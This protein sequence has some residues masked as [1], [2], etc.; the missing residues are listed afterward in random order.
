MRLKQLFESKDQL[1]ISIL[2]A[3][4]VI[5][6]KSDIE[7]LLN[8]EVEIE[9]KTDGTKLTVLHINDNG[10]LN[11]WII[12]YKNQIMYS[13]EFSFQDSKQII[14]KSIGISQYKLVLDHFSNLG[15]TGLPINTEFAIEFLQRKPTLSS[16]YTNPHHLVLIGYSQCSYDENEI[17]FGTLKTNSKI[18]ETEN[19]DE[20]AKLLQVD[21]P[22]KLFKGYLKD[23]KNGIL[24][25]SLRDVYNKNI[26]DFNSEDP[27]VL[28]KAITKTLLEVESVY[29]GKEE[30]V[31]IKYD[32]KI[33]KVQQEYQLD[34][35]ARRLIKQKY[36][37]ENP[38][39]EDL[40]WKEVINASRE[41][42]SKITRGPINLRLKKLS[43]L[44]EK[45]DFNISH[46]KKNELQ[47]KDDI[48]HNA[49]I[50]ILKALKGN[51]GCLILGKFRVLTNGHCN[52]INKALKEY[53]KV[54]VCLV[55]SK[56]TKATRDLRYKMLEKTFKNKIEIIEHN[57][58]NI[59][60]M[61]SKSPFNINTVFC[62]SDRYFDYVKQVEKVLGL[63]VREYP[64]DSDAISAT[65]VISNIRDK[66]FFEKNTPK[67]IHSLYPEILAT[68][69]EISLG[70][71]LSQGKLFVDYLEEDGEACGGGDCGDC[72]DCAL[73]T[74]SANIAPVTLPLGSDILR[75]KA[76][77]QDFSLSEG[78]KTVK[79]PR[80]LE[81]KLKN[82]I[83]EEFI[84]E[85]NV[86]TDNIEFLLR[87]SLG[88]SW[89]FDGFKCFKSI[90]QFSSSEPSKK[91]FKIFQ[92]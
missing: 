30:G 52:V 78:N 69:D 10:D 28:W 91:C 27:E 6:T 54:L 14:Q 36:M 63:D 70:E 76:K 66:E 37:E 50:L 71:G 11:D 61:L 35:N 29:G 2:S 65:K 15:K 77:E 74:T 31:V 60:G 13:E 80:V 12:A 49:K 43:E 24:S 73:G 90:L 84:L 72:G 51:N 67:E 1:D 79:I 39:D 58:G 89:K 57:S 62:G 85:Q 88:D 18:M 9:H 87:E 41:I 33:I 59:L 86:L 22:N 4:K 56:D 26:E 47:I 21:V 48:H 8:T 34:Q 81:R 3:S 83:N 92:N 55:S 25:N 23:F 42:A 17:K 45:T 19:R 82:L 46:S 44:L 53:D 7:S 40:Y 64:R 5:K 68:Y 20:Y 32:D 75:R 38:E 16:N